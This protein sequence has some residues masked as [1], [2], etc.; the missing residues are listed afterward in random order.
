MLLTIIKACFKVEWSSKSINPSLI[1][2]L[3]IRCKKM[4]PHCVLLP[5]FCERIARQ[6]ARLVGKNQYPR[7][8]TFFSRNR[9]YC[10]LMKTFHTC[11]ENLR[12]GLTFV[13]VCRRSPLYNSY[14]PVFEEESV[15]PR[16]NDNYYPVKEVTRSFNGDIEYIDEIIDEDAISVQDTTN[17]GRMGSLVIDGN[18]KRPKCQ[19]VGAQ[20]DCR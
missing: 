15:Y 17:K 3:Y 7:T 9:S 5:G 4:L 19:P 10:Y 8:Q 20:I 13:F 18:D 12:I 6:T 16:S 11:L 1:Y 2:N 14:F